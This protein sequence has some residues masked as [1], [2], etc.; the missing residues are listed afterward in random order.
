MWGNR[1]DHWTKLVDLQ[2]KAENVTGIPLAASLIK[3][4]GSNSSE[5]FQAHQNGDLFDEVVIEITGRAEPGGGEVVVERITLTGALISTVRRYAAVES[6]GGSNK[7]L[8]NYGLVFQRY[9]RLPV[10]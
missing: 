5:L 9:T 4:V 2:V 8:E 10:P 3:E 7:L 6:T 1:R